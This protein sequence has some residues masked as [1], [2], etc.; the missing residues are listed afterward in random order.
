MLTP[1]PLPPG[2]GLR[3]RLLLEQIMVDE[4]EIVEDSHCEQV[5][6]PDVTTT[7]SLY[8]NSGP[9]QRRDSS[10]HDDYLSV[11]AGENEPLT[12][13]HGEDDAVTLMQRQE[14]GRWVCN[15]ADLKQWLQTIATPHN[16]RGATSTSS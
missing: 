16:H 4:P 15:L 5:V 2:Q 6:P 10:F 3:L 13:R 9:W 8:Y 11:R 14:M 1:Q 7:T 12:R